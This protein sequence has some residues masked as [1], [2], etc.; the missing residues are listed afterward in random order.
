MYSSVMIHAQDIHWSQFQMS[1]L[2]LNPAQT[3][4]FD[5]DYRFIGNHRNQWKSVTK[6]YTTFSGSVDAGL[7]IL[8]TERNRYN[9]GIL[10]NNDKAGDS[11]LGT[12]Q[13]ALS[14]SVIRALDKDGVHFVS[15][16]LQTGYVS[17][18]INYSDLY[19][20]EQ[21]DGDVYNPGSGNTENF[22]NSKH[23]YVDFNAGVAWLMQTENKFKLGA[24]FSIQ[25]I[26]RPDDS[27]FSTPA[28][29]FPR[30]QG[31]VKVELPVAS[32]FDLIPSVLF[33]NQGSFQE[34][35]GGTSVRYRISELPGRQYAFSVGGWFRSKDALIASAGLDYNALRVGVSYDINTSDLD[36][37]SNG[38][39]GYEI[40]LIYIVRKVKPI[41][42]KPPCPLY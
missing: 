21:F 39:G 28:K 8:S 20:D 35:V 11:K 19:F 27:F 33:Q 41:G 12:T 17:R 42:I 15:L 25:H 34:L 32:R 13:F 29:V 16:G 24:G 40:S 30:L 7:G 3:G 31:D 5:G 22:D 2:N 38:K 26:N 18:S 23:G 6:P 1:P 9:A 37:A 14:L 10:F 4:F 36:R